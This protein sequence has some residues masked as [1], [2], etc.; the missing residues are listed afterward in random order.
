M[1]AGLVDGINYNSGDATKATLVLDAPLKDFVYV[2]GSFNNWLPTAAYAIKKDDASGKFWLELTGLASGTNYTYQYWVVDATPIANTPSV[3]KTADPYSTLVLNEEDA[4][5]SCWELSQFA[6]LSSRTGAR[7]YRFA[8]WANSLC[9]E[10]VNDQFRET[11]KRTNW[12]CT[13][14]W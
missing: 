9:L 12:W 11:G 13:K 10:Y 4:S 2:A 14:F 3:V 7:S 8:D 1:P 6:G 5:I